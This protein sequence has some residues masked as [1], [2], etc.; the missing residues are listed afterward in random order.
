MIS[1]LELVRVFGG[2][3]DAGCCASMPPADIVA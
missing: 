1:G 2:E 3:M